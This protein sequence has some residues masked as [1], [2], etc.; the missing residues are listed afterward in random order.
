M[1]SRIYAIISQINVELPVKNQNNGIQRILKLWEKEEDQPWHNV[2]DMQT[3][4]R[5]YPIV[6]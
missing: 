5:L 6:A 1:K 3:L 2:K 4:E